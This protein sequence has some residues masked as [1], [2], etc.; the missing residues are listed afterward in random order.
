MQINL[1]KK[2]DPATLD[3]IA[4]FI[5]GDDIEKYPVY[6]SSMF[7]TKFFQDI[8]INVRH[9]GSTRKWWTLS[10]LEQLISKDLE[11]VILRLVDI[12]EYKADV[13]KLKISLKSMNNILFME[14]LKVSL[15]GRTPF[16]EAIS[17]NNNFSTMNLEDK[18]EESMEEFL[19]KDFKEHD[20]SVL[21]LGMEIESILKSRISEA[22]N[23]LK[24]NSN[25]SA[26][27][28]VGSTLEGLL[29]G[30]ATKYPKEFN[31]NASAPKDKAQKVKVL[32]NWTFNE[33]INVAY[34]LSFLDLDIKKFSHIMRDFRNYIHPYEQMAS[35]FSPTQNTAK[36]CLQVLNGAIENI[37]LESKKRNG[38]K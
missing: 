22:Q 15:N 8:G 1:N 36:I 28:M 3:A 5:C 38:K 37:I 23:N 31:T 32:N 24:N 35:K 29:L 16:L 7:L 12:R 6:R 17:T 27:F 30:L 2:L 4:D 10:V 34:S 21:D 9:D 11:K 33:F 26:V 18:V 13:E 20:I 19:E 14:D 25:L